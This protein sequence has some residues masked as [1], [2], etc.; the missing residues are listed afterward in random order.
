MVEPYI[1]RITLLFNKFGDNDV[2]YYNIYGGITPQP[3]EIMATSEEPFIHMF[4]LNNLTNYYFRVAAV[5]S[6]GEES[7]YSNEVMVYVRIIPP[8]DNMITNGDFSDGFTDWNFYVNGDASAN[9]SVTASEE[10]EVEITDGGSEYWH[11]QALYPNLTLIEGKNYI[12]EFEAYASGNRLI[13][14]EIKKNGTPWTNYSRIG[15]TYLTE[16]KERFSHQFTMNE[17]N[18][19]QARVEFN[20]GMEN[21]DVF[22]DNVSLREVVTGIQ[23][24]DPLRPTKFNLTKNYPNPFN[25]T[26]T[27]SY[28]V[29]ELSYVSITIYNV[30]GEE[31]ETLIDRPHGPGVHEIKF[32][33]SYYSSGIY[34]Y[35]LMANSLNGSKLYNQVKK[36]MLLK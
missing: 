34:Y 30:L 23:N 11:V 5:N 35:Q 25:P 28:Q 3:T 27:I 10:M 19:F 15:L 17:P 8:G 26:T 32:D 36:M 1:D 16:T 22:I 14:A 24:P 12:F 2:A 21:I 20:I 6:A 4:N 31:L 33:G 13:E 18:E 29:P 9:H 7:Y